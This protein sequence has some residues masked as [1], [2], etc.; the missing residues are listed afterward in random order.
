ML[1]TK[2]LSTARSGLS[3]GA[4]LRVAECFCVDSGAGLE[5]E[6]PPEARFVSGPPSCR[7]LNDRIRLVSRSSRS[8]LALL[9]WASRRARHR[10]RRT[11]RWTQSRL[12]RCGRLAHSRYERWVS[13]ISRQQALSEQI[14]LSRVRA[15]GSVGECKIHSDI[16]IVLPR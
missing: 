12:S 9:R 4:P 2:P 15:V 13:D 3:S 11:R 6:P 14:D 8:S 7:R 16:S 1:K 5:I 10:C